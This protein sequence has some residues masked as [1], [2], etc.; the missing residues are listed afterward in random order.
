MQNVKISICLNKSC[1]NKRIIIEQETIQK[2]QAYLEKHKYTELLEIKSLIIEIMHTLNSQ[3]EQ[4][5]RHS[6][7]RTHVPV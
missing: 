3:N 1:N 5:I 7:K 2:V 4:I 6:R